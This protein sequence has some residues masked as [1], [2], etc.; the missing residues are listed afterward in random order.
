MVGATLA[1]GAV[2]PP[3]AS[4]AIAVSSPITR[5]L[6]VNSL[7]V[8]WS[9]TTTPRLIQMVWTCTGGYCLNTATSPVTL[10]LVSTASHA[11]FA[12]NPS[13]SSVSDFS[14]WPG[15][16]PDGTWSVQMKY[17][18]T[19]SVTSVAV[20]G[21]ATSTATLPPTLASPAANLATNATAIPVS[22]TLPGT[23]SLGSNPTL[24]FT[25]VNTSTA[26]ILTLSP[27]VTNG[28][29]SLDPAK[30]PDNRHEEGNGR[31][32]HRRSSESRWPCPCV[33]DP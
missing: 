4:A 3:M 30:A 1:A 28:S 16:M 12:Y 6:Y 13:S 17:T 32:L 7:F 18:D 20:T 27:S 24:S 14:N 2:A 33:G 21:V 10:D 29:F 22:Y 25:N 8:S 5:N 23:P 26:S 9:T 11:S 31:V 15:T 19:N